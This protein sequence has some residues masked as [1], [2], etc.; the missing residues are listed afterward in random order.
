MNKDDLKEAFEGVDTV[1]HT[2]GLIS[3]GTHPDFEAMIQVNVYGKYKSCHGVIVQPTIA[4]WRHVGQNGGVCQCEV[5]RT[6]FFQTVK[7]KE[8]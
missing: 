1:F 3:F 8:S 4:F 2:A 5:C 6:H 7:L